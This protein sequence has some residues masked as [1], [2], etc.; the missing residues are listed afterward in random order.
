MTS[1][2]RASILET[3]FRLFLEKGYDGTSLSDILAEVPY[4]KGALYH[5]FGS[6]EALLEAVIERFFTDPLTEPQFPR[7]A[8][9]VALAHR[10]VDDYVDAIESI[11]QVATP[12]SYYAFLLAVAPRVQPALLAA[13][14]HIEDELAAALASVMPAGSEA[15]ARAV[16]GDII[17]LVEGT[18]LLDVIQQ[19]VPDRARL[20]A[21]V[22][23]LIRV[24][25]AASV[26]RSDGSG[27]RCRGGASSEEGALAE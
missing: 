10:L 3:A 8:T 22:D 24:H 1:A 21:R 5:H 23:E 4:S 20:R 18:G 16:A 14:D 6:K 15:S 7:P 17:A 11:A 25:L 27:E 13:S 12:L 26:G 19:R 9:P 2:A